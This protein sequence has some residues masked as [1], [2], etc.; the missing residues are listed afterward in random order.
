MHSP[1]FVKNTKL[2]ALLTIVGIALV[3]AVY[4]PL[5]MAD[6]KTTST[7]INANLGSVISLLSSSGTVNLAVAPTAAGAQTTASDTVTVSTNNALGYRL[8]LALTGAPS[9]LASGGNSIPA[10]SGTQAAPVALAANTWGYRVDGVGGFGAGPTS[11]QSSTA[12]GSTTYAAVPATASPAQLKN[13][14]T[15]AT[16]DTTPVWYSV[17][18]NTGTPSGTYTNSVTYTAVTN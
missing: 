13:T 6:T 5:A 12:L 10:T 4:A 9:A 1:L 8:Q 7:T 17:A 16:N 3:A 15:T 18:V 14:S 11:S 2:P